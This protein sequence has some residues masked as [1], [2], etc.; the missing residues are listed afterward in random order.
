M[1]YFALFAAMVVIAT[2]AFGLWSAREARRWAERRART[3]EPVL[4]DG[5]PVRPHV[6][7]RPP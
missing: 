7:N 5:A 3:A 2:V 6:R 1:L 4:N